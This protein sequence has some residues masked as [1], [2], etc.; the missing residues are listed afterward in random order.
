MSTLQLVTGG[1]LTA[2]GFASVRTKSEVTLRVR[3]IAGGREADAKNFDVDGTVQMSYVRQ[4][5]ARR[6]YSGASG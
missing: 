2:M 6:T 3:D 4:L 5:I 1:V